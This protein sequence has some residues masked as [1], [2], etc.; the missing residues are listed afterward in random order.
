MSA[1]LRLALLGATGRMGR[2]L[3]ESIAATPG[4]TLAAT[5][6]VAGDPLL[7]VDAGKLAGAGKL[8]ITVSDDLDAAVERCD[9]LVDFSR[10]QGTRAAAEAA[11][12]AGRP[13]LSGTTGLDAETEI[14]LQRAARRVAVCQAANFS[15][16]VNLCLG[17]VAQ[18]AARLG[19]EYDVEILDAHHRHKVDAP[20]GTAL[21]LGRAVA[22]ARGTVLEKVAVWQRHGHTGER[23]DAAIGFAVLRAGD[24]VGEHTVIFAAAGERMEIRHVATSRAN[25]ARGALR[26]AVWLAAQPPG[27]YGMREVLGLDAGPGGAR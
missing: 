25:F 5:V 14:A 1:P 27:F 9:V 6:T 16:G 19:I 22:D 11:A 3:I 26:A 2:A 7:G 4:L 21:A 13:L 15:I 20:S 8:G 12:A 17:L 18:A 10:P 24:I 23:P